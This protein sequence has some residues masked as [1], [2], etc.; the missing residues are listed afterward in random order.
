MPGWSTA[1]DPKGKV[2]YMN[3]IKKTTSWKR[4]KP[5]PEAPLPVAEVV[6]TTAAGGGFPSK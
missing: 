6:G 5:E 2:Y 3:H 1:R 4:P